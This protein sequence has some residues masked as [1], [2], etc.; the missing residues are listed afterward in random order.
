M[1]GFA[2]RLRLDLNLLTLL[3]SDNPE[4][5]TFFEVTK[6]IGLQSLLIVLVRMPPG[7]DRHGSESVV[8]LLAEN[9]SGSPLITKMRY[10]R[11]VDA[12]PASFQE[13]VQYLPLFLK[14]DDIKAL[15]AKLSDPEIRRQVRENK[16]LMM[17]PF[18]IPR[19][20]IC[21]DPLGLRD[22]FLAGPGL[23]AGG[24][25]PRGSFQGYFRSKKDRVYF[26]FLKPGHPPQDVHF[27]KKLMAEMDRLTEQSL[28]N[29]RQNH[30]H[31]EGKILVS[32]T[33]GYP[34]AV[35]DEATTKKDIKATLLTS[36]LGIMILFGLSFRTL[37]ILVYVGLTL[38][39]GL[40]WTLGFAELVF[41]H[42]N[43][44]TCVFS[45]VL[46]GLGIDF[47]IHIINRYF[48]HRNTGTDVKTRL[49]NTFDEVGTGIVIGAVTT[50][51][52]F[53]AI[54]LSDFG[55]FR[56]LGVMTGTGILFCMIVMVIVLPSLLIWSSG[57]KFSGFG[58]KISIAGFGL[59]PLL[60][61][62]QRHPRSWLLVSLMVVCLLGVAGTRIR[63]DDNLR[64]LR[65][66]DTKAFLLQDKVA[67][68]MGGS[69]DKVLLVTHDRTKTGVME[70]CASIYN[71]LEA[72]RKKGRIG[73]VNSLS[74]YLAAPG[75]QRKN[76][77]FIQ[78]HPG[79]FD[80]KR[81]RRTFDR[82]LKENGFRELK[83]YDRYFASLSKVFSSTRIFFPGALKN[84]PIS[85]FLKPFIYYEDGYFRSVT[86]ISPRGNL[87]SR[88][89]TAAF[90]KM[91]TAKLHEQGVPENRYS[92]TGVSLLTGALKEVIIKN[93]ELSMWVAVLVILMV[94]LGYYRNLKYCALSVLPVVS[95]LLSLCGIMVMFKVD[96]NFFNMIVVPMIVGIGVDDGVHLTNTFR[97]T[98]GGD[99]LE[100]TVGT[101]RAVV[102]TSIT[103]LVG[104][105]SIGLSHYPGL[106]SMGYVA[107]IGLIA[108]LL[109]SVI[110]LP[111][112]FWSMKGQG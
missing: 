55:G 58:G 78:Q 49:G 17:M 104:F 64:N 99:M 101:G 18:G 10:K 72:L 2:S 90:R 51:A 43:I 4:V 73:W 66:P 63:F 37:K 35:S 71:G 75:R 12:S 50:A 105:G 7:L 42:L 54:S 44:L 85:G 61:R 60:R 89:D 27:S 93:M 95:A 81:I 107:V 68:W 74:R 109:A 102:L 30:K 69:M 41:H 106:R 86:Y 82:A 45:C 84:T 100:K 8:D 65:P 28:R 46:V 3:P 32:Y 97:Q 22:V 5:N 83:V 9:Y 108:C 48:S 47:A 94:L 57:R 26:L 1:V 111:A 33:G 14:N 13:F 67:A 59:R 25:M 96:F 36:F 103:T 20:I 76:I 34:I 112:L 6:E 98:K 40:A 110:V 52:A 53:Y 15:A 31:I 79:A 38:A 80:M 39:I 62:I 24:M 87:W 11:N 29:F 70:T 16:R 56:E 23:P 19:E 88:S 21:A 92:L 77:E 91:I